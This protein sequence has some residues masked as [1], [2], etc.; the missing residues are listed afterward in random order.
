MCVLYSILKHGVIFYLTISSE[1]KDLSGVYRIIC[2]DNGKQYFGE[3]SNFGRRL[4]EHNYSLSRG[5]HRNPY[6]Q[7]DYNKY[8]PDAFSFEVVSILDDR[9]EMDILEA[10]MIA[11]AR[12]HE[13]CYNIFD[14]G[15]YGSVSD[16]S[17]GEKASIRN[18]GMVVPPERRETMSDSAKKQW[19]NEEYRELMINSA[20]KQWENPE[21]REKMLSVHKGKKLSEEQKALLRS[22]N[23]GR[24]ATDET[25]MKMSLKRRGEDNGRA[26]LTA[27]QVID[28]RARAAA[29]EDYKDLALEYSVSKSTA[30]SIINYKTWK[31]I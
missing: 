28:M 8:G 11:D 25:K 17:F 16:P 2:L 26:K 14:G 9:N 23:V 21:Y 5:E 30:S 12:S 15:R 27:D 19:E 18:K 4:G 6:L 13:L 7:E 29:G 24:K 10:S 1:Y 31:Y 22:V 3:T 20:K